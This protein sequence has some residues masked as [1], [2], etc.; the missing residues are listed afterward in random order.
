M[1]S[2]AI[3]LALFAA[4]IVASFSLAAATSAAT[5]TETSSTS[6]TTATTTSGTEKGK[7]SEKSKAKKPAC[8]PN[9]KIVLTGEYVSAGADGKSFAMKV[10][11]GNA[12]AKA[13]KGKQVTVSFDE[14]TKFAGKKRKA[15][16]LAAGDRLN[17]QGLACK[18]DAAAL[19]VLARKVTSKAP[20]GADDAA[21]TTAATTTTGS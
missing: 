19:T 17:V 5:G 21:A 1:K 15:A 16:D 11:G 12:F 2:K 3:L 9:K 6:T 18:A 4:G 10:N 13:L 20:K 14:K 8:K 7:G